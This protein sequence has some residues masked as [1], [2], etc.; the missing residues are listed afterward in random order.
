MKTSTQ[1]EK[2]RGSGGA[3]A[4]AWR[5]THRITFTPRHGKPQVC[6]VMLDH[7]PAYTREEWDTTSQADWEL[8]GKEWLHLGMTTPGGAVGRVGI[9]EV[10]VKGGAG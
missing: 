8:D 7:G 2:F 10:K 1:K 5:A 4:S 3:P 6:D 9:E